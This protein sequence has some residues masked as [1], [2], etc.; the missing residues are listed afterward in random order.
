MRQFF[1]REPNGPTAK[2]SLSVTRC[3]PPDQ[4]EHEVVMRQEAEGEPGKFLP[5]ARERRGSQTEGWSRV[6]FEP[7][8]LLPGSAGPTRNLQELTAAVADGRGF[9]AERHGNARGTEVS[10]EGRGRRGR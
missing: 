4:A 1:L 3:Q 2:T 8:F 6:T 9:V 10:A 7:L 5:S